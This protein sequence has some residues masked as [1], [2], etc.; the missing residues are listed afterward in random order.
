VGLENSQFGHSALLEPKARQAGVSEN[1][2]SGSGGRN[3]AYDPH[4]F[5]LMAGDVESNPGPLT[6]TRVDCAVCGGRVKGTDGSL[7]CGGCGA[8]C[9]KQVRCSGL[10]RAR[11]VVGDW[12]CPH[13]SGLQRHN[14][15]A[16]R[17]VQTSS[18]TVGATTGGAMTGGVTT[19]PMPQPREACLYCNKG[20]PAGAN[21]L[22]CRRCRRTSHKCCSR[23]TRAEIDSHLVGSSWECPDCLRAPQAPS[24]AVTVVT[25]REPKK[26]FVP[27]GQLRILQWN[28]NGARTKKAELEQLLLKHRVDVCLV[29]ETKLGPGDANPKYH[30]YT[31]VR[32]DR[33]CEVGARR[34]PG[35]GLMTIVKE[36][37]PFSRMPQLALEPGSIL[38][39]LT[40]G[41]VARQGLTLKVCNVYC[42]PVRAIPGETR[43]E[44]FDVDKL[45][46]GDKVLIAGDLNAHAGLWDLVQPEDALGAQLTEWLA[47][48]GM[49]TVNDGGATRINPATGG[50]S[51]PDVTIMHAS[52]V[53]RVSW[54]ID[55]EVGSDHAAVLT[56]VEVAL[57]GISEASEQRCGWNWQKADWASY[58][59]LTEDELDGGQWEETSESLT[60][61]ERRFSGVLRAA[62]LKHIGRLKTS[63]FRKPW[64]TPALRE[65]I[66]YR[67]QLR[68]NVAEHR[69]EWVDAC[70]RVQDVAE[71][72]RKRCWAE[73]VEELDGAADQSKVWRVM[74]GLSG[75]S[76]SSSKNEALLHNGRSLVGNEAKADA[77]M[78]AYAAVSR[79]K[80]EP[81]DRSVQKRVAKQMRG[82]Y[83]E[84]SEERP[85]SL[86][87]L[88]EALLCTKTKGAPGGDEIAPPLL[89]NLGPVGKGVLLKLLN[90]SW[91]EG[92]CPQSWRDAVIIPLLKSGK[93]AEKVDSYRPVSLTS[94]IAKTLE[95]MVAARLHHLAESR[96]WWSCKQAGFRRLHSTEDQVLRL[97]QSIS[98]GFQARKPLRTVLALLD[99]SKAFDTVWR[100]RLLDGMLAKGVPR[101]Y[102]QWVSGFL[103]N[104]RGAV[105]WFGSCGRW[106]GLKQ[107][108]PQGAVL[109]PLLFLFFIDAVTEVLP[110]HV[111]VS[112]YADDIA[113]WSRHQDKL[114]AAERV[115][116]AVR[117]VAEWSSA[118]KLQ[119]NAAKCEVSF[120]STD[121]HEARHVPLVMLGERRLAH[122]PNPVFLG[123]CYDRML[124]F[125]PHVSRVC[126]RVQATC[127]VLSAVAARS[128]GC[129]RRTLR[130]L[131]MALVRGTMDYCGA[132]WQ[133]WVAQSGVDELERA[134]NRALRVVSGQ[135]R[136]TPVEAVRAEVGVPRYADVVEYLAATAWEK[137]RRLPAEHP[138]AMAAAGNVAHRTRRSSWRVL[139]TKVCE[140]SGLAATAVSALRWNRPEPWRWKDS[141]RWSASLTLDGGSS[142]ATA[143]ATLH[144]DALDTVTR[145][146][147]HCRWIAYTDGSAMGG[148]SDGGSAAVITRGDPADPEV[149]HVRRRRGPQRTCS[150]DTEVMA[151]QLALDWCESA[152][153][154][155]VLV[156]TD[157]Q[158]LLR[159]LTSE[160][161]KDGE[162]VG[163]LRRRLSRAG[164]KVWL[165]W[166]PGHCGLPGNERADFEAGVAAGR[167]A[168]VDEFGMGMS[169]SSPLSAVITYSAAKSRL[170]EECLR[171]RVMHTRVAAVYG[172]LGW[173]PVSPSGG[174]GDHVLIAQLRSGHCAKLAA[175][176]RI[177]NPS[178]DPTC[179]RC[180]EEPQDVE[181]W[182]QRCPA[183][184]ARRENVF[185]CAS[186]PLSVLC[187]QPDK[188]VTYAKQSLSGCL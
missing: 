31:V 106:K 174:R 180:G 120:F 135:L 14:T 74:K 144:K 23:M 113:I 179:T 24:S 58:Q 115:E 141:Q 35:G 28:C 83:V 185:G 57:D 140:D 155:E 167:G 22:R 131:F 118:A 11:Q 145:C 69:Q 159:A 15:L 51:S 137:A 77:F 65:A 39:D 110:D 92:E 46:S 76:V 148:T 165:Q 20:V 102:V 61:W 160:S 150:F 50:S 53:S 79:Y 178:A 90:R 117:A 163:S 67:N 16:G 26:A 45:P 86:D 108:V 105:K 36:D 176:S 183:L 186:P 82:P 27:R 129:S 151:M 55:A 136:T 68:R 52:W 81:D 123:V 122:N 111:E 181:H 101:R 18:A 100:S 166:V 64:M 43:P 134:Q 32:R 4:R 175:Y 73:F 171:E 103:R 130:S 156:C 66:R 112:M 34:I 104:R 177:V 149:L 70:R 38:E 71:E 1:V 48:S 170:K 41:I 164:R 94:C 121:T 91:S 13:C 158:A 30:G 59:K 152:G 9:H 42:P 187:R 143:L 84:A 8:R 95:R 172:I 128:W 72:E 87:E 124:S 169:V 182:L 138:R 127:R 98:D 173:R 7:M 44:G 19:G 119:L 56:V 21:P 114:I 96:G 12:R 188:A 54:T 17:P 146:G 97:S 33:Q 85:F 126:G 62:A 184:V 154:G 29:Q 147:V 40:I 49:I 168:T 162:A 6:S 47:D 161:A 93:P 116:E 37:V 109:S 78:S 99:F 139:A 3:P 25:K 125:G 60:I 153:D 133:P 10:T 63:A 157:S 107:G 5:L 142:K 75:K 89:Q 2:F 88:E 132:A 80:L